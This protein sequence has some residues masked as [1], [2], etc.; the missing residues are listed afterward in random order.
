MRLRN[1]QEDTVKGIKESFKRGNK[2]IIMS[3]STGAGKTVM[4]S[5][6]AKEA[7]D[8]GRKVLV[9]SHRTSLLTQANGTFQAF[10]IRAERIEANRKDINFSFNV[11]VGMIETLSRRLKNKEYADFLDSIDLVI[12]DE[13]HIG[14]FD[15]IFKHLNPKTYVIGATATPVRDTKVKLKEFYSDIVQAIDTPELVKRGMLVKCLEYG[16]KTDLSEAKSRNG[17]FDNDSVADIFEKTKLY[18]GVISNY[19]RVCD[20]SKAILFA[21]NIKSAEKITEE[22]SKEGYKARI[23]HS[24]SQDKEEVLEWFKTAKTGILVNV[25]ILTAG[26]DCPDIETIILYRA[27]KSVSLYLQMVGRGSRLHKGKDHFKV[28]DFGGNVQRHGSW[29]I[30]RKWSLEEEKKKK[31]D[32]LGMELTKDCPKCEAIVR[33]SAK[34]CTGKRFDPITFELIDCGYIFN[35]PTVT[36]EEEKELEL[37]VDISEYNV[38]NYYKKGSLSLGMLAILVRAKK[39]GN[40]SAIM[41]VYNKEGRTGAQNL[42]DLLGYKKGFLHTFLNKLQ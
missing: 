28:L 23:I 19:K 24:N 20:N 34:V 8:K 30:N 21:S 15:K 18:K 2:R 12:I 26:F 42:C 9:L 17:D 16:I 5:Y 10:G 36:E 13:C 37:L 3:A 33:V 38:K 40:R 41:L 25:N 27:T 22:L 1:Y 14:S 11:Y 6:M 35:K 31:S 7:S 4:F 29:C 39:I 32:A